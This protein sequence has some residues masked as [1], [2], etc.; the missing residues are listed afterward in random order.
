LIDLGFAEA[1]RVCARGLVREENQDCT[2]GTRIGEEAWL[3]GVFDGMG[4]HQGGKTAAQIA[5]KR[6]RL[7]LRRRWP[8]EEADRYDVLL[9]S[10]DQADRAIRRAESRDLALRGLGATA[11]AAVVEPTRVSYLH[12]GDCRFHHFRE[13]DLIHSSR[14]HTI[15]QILVET[16]RIR[17]DEVNTHPMRSAVTSSLGGGKEATLDVSPKWGDTS[18]GPWL[19]PCKSGD[20]VLLTSDGVHGEISEEALREA[21]QADSA[22]ETVRRLARASLASGARDNFSAI[23]IRYTR[24]GPRA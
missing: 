14:D 2:L 15:V 13:G 5:R 6:F 8:A 12:A 7:G 3:F 17:A 22:A 11:V 16:G 19:M 18:D 21:C 1:A 4:G 9:K 23:A 24:S 10:F 20:V